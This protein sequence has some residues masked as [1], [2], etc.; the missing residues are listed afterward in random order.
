MTDTAI[1][2]I[3]QYTIHYNSNTIRFVD[4]IPD[5]DT[6][7]Y[8][9]VTSFCCVPDAICLTDSRLCHSLCT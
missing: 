4:P 8:A 1:L 7:V 3:F 2:P 5:T 6:Y 9:Y